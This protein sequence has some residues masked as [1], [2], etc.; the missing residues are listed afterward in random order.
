VGS[1]HEHVAYF[2]HRDNNNFHVGGTWMEASFTSLPPEL[3]FEP[4]DMKSRDGTNAFFSVTTPDSSAIF[5]WRK[6]GVDIPGATSA[7]LLLTNVSAIGAGDYS[8]AVSNAFGTTESDPATLTVAATGAVRFLTM[9]TR[10]EVGRGD[11]VLIP[12]LVINGDVA[13]TVLVRA[14]GPALLDFGVSGFLEDPTFTVFR[15]LPGG[16]SEAVA[17]NDNWEDN[18]DLPELVATSQNVGAF[19][20]PVGSHDAAMLLVL[21]PGSYTVVISGVGETEG[22]ALLEVYLVAP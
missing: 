19:D 2:D 15:S 10:A 5:Q 4:V 21:N 18:P 7:M 9:S 22:V 3:T 12:G 8:V 14:V 17:G 6:D 20:L 11:Q 13:M 16:G 1:S